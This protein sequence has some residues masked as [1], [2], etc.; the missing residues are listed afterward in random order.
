MSY[1]PL[2]RNASGIVFFG[3]SSTDSVFE[4]NS[5]FTFDGT[6]YSNNI[7]NS[8]SRDELRQ[9]LVKHF[10]IAHSKNEIAW[11]NRRYNR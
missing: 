1:A 5:S 10:E 4:S 11:M 3:A 2:D 7:V 8:E 6:N 9:L